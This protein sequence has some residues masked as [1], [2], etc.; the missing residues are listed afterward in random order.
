MTAT[1]ARPGALES[2][3]IVEAS[4]MEFAYA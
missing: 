3:Y 1:P 4:V 2:A